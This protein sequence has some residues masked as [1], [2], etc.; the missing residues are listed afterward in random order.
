MNLGQQLTTCVIL[1]QKIL[2]NWCNG[3]ISSLENGKD[4][5][6]SLYENESLLACITKKMLAQDGYQRG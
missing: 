5:I 3:E 1:S 6:L 2:T 4:Q